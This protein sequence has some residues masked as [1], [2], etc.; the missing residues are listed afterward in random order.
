MK[1]LD[2][3]KLSVEQLVKMISP[4]SEVVLELKRRGVVRSRN[5]VG[6]LGEY[7]TIETYKNNSSL[8]SLSIAPPGVRN[9]DA[10][11][12]KGEI[13]SI[14][15]IT[16]RTGTTGSFWDPKSIER[17]EKKF[18]YLIIVI[19]NNNY[20]V[21]LIL[22]L[23]WNQFFEKKSY[24]RRMDNYNISVTKSLINESKIIHGKI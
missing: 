5:T 2:F 21:D 24:N 13:Y 6:D 15:T 9:V 4:S 22:E 23:T 7:Y 17:N 18:D 1:N 12:R 19:L 3:K 11:S 16:S 14:K 8:P 20:T 10:L